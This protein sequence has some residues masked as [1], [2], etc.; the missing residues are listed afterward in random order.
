MDAPIGTAPFAVRAYAKERLD[1]IV[2][3]QNPT[4]A[5]RSLL[6]QMLSS[7]STITPKFNAAMKFPSVDLIL[8]KVL[9]FVTGGKY[10]EWAAEKL[11]SL[12]GFEWLHAALSPQPA[13]TSDKP[14]EATA[15]GSIARRADRLPLQE[16]CNKLF[17]PFEGPMILGD[18]LT[19]KTPYELI[20]SYIDQDFDPLRC[21]KMPKF[22]RPI[23]IEDMAIIFP[24]ET[25]RLVACVLRTR[26][27]A[28]SQMHLWK[29]FFG[30][31][32]QLAEKK[33]E[34]GQ[35]AQ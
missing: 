18:G 5:Q 11:R 22:D 32:A 26:D 9:C 24:K 4:S 19:V 30:K 8:Y 27:F 23:G 20:N 3:E 16:L 17:R 2:K 25:R 29:C 1:Q 21:E 34:A 13:S 12:N 7:E 14:V 31:V 28:D 33:R 10:R 15:L 6:T 35:S